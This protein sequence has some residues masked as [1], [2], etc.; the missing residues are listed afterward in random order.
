MRIATLDERSYRRL[1]WDHRPLRDFWRVG[2]GY[3]T[4]LEAHGLYTMGDIARCSI[5]KPEEY[6]NEELLYRL[7]GVNAELLIDHAWGWEP[8][9]IADIQVYEPENKSTVSGQVLACAYEWEKA[10]LVLKEMADQLGLDLVA[11]GLVTD[12]L[13]LHVGYDIDNLKNEEPGVGY[14]GETKIDRYGRKLPKP[15]HGTE[16]LGESTASSRLLREHAMALYDRIVDKKLLIRRLSLEAGHLISKEKAEKPEEFHQMDLF[17][18]YHIEE[19]GKEQTGAEG[20]KLQENQQKK[21]LE[22]KQSEKERKLQEAMLDIRKRFGKNA[23]LK[24]MN[25]EEGATARE[26]NTQIGGHKA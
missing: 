15:A 18:D 3:E 24:G 17:A 21:E 4:K 6:Y 20:V 8:C 14:Q 23:V 7:F 5:G 2:K 9:T 19:A 25:L 1:L 13:V 26:R 22:K 16:N 11:K 10:R 12:Q